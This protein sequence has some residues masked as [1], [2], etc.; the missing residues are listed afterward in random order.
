MYLFIDDLFHLYLTGW[1][2]RHLSPGEKMRREA[3]AHAISD[4]QDS[5]NHLI[6][7]NE[8]AQKYPAMFSQTQMSCDNRRPVRICISVIWMYYLF[9][10]FC[11]FCKFYLLL[12]AEIWRLRVK[13]ICG[14]FNSIFSAKTGNPFEERAAFNQ[15]SKISEDCPDNNFVLLWSRVA[16]STFY[17]QLPWP[18][19]WPNKYS[20]AAIVAAIECD[21]I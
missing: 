14:S 18:P 10:F 9:I 21:K 17:L 2:L 4:T 7:W 19:M 13:I 6:T 12:F 1:E 20:C 5:N 3:T 11:F 8:K 16:A 15:T